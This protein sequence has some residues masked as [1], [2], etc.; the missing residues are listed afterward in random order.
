[1]LKSRVIVLHT[2]ARADGSRTGVIGNLRSAQSV[3]VAG[4]DVL[5]SSATP[6]KTVMD[7]QL[8]LLCGSVQQSR[9]SGGCTDSKN[10]DWW[11]IIPFSKNKETLVGS[12]RR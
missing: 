9:C 11:I 8:W 2:M 10:V 6:D 12:I 5:N 4:I 7:R 1:M 3:P